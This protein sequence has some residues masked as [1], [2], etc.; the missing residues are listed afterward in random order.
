MHG[1]S[2][3]I[4]TF[5]TYHCGRERDQSGRRQRK[6]SRAEEGAMALAA[7]ARPSPGET[8]DV[9]FLV[10]YSSARYYNALVVG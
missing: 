5:E 8:R 7:A 4:D 1:T 2:K 6:A 10:Y 3:I 9:N